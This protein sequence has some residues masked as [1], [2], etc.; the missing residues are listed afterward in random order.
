MLADQL[1]LDSF[2]SQIAAPAKLQDDL[3]PRL[4]NF[5]RL[6]IQSAVTAIC[7]ALNVIFLEAFSPLAK[8]WSGD[9]TT[10]ANQ[11]EIFSLLIELNP[12]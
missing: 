2:G 11:T 8:S 7:Q 10:A 5:W 3:F 9:S 12:R 4:G 1:G 6:G